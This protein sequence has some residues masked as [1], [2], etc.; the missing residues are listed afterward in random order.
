MKLFRNFFYLL[1]QG[2]IGIFRNSIM[3]TASIL[4]LIC[5]MLIVG[6]FGL[7]VKAV[8]DNLERTNDLNVIVA[9]ISPSATDEDI[10][11]TKAE[12]EAYHTGITVTYI[13]KETGLSRL[14]EEM[15]SAI[16]LSEY[17]NGERPN[18]LPDAFEITFENAEGAEALNNFINNLEN[19]TDTRHRIGLVD[20]VDDASKGLMAIA[21]VLMGMLFIVALFVIM[22]TIKLGVFARRDEIAVMRYV[23]ATN[24]FIVT[25]Y[26]IE[27][28]II[29]IFS[30]A[31]AFGIQYYLYT[32][33][34]ADIVVSS[35]IGTVAPFGEIAV[36]VAAG[37]LGLGLFAGTVG[38][39]VSI[40]KYLGQ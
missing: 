40:K 8:D 12:I 27:G 30:A 2:I 37:F 21:V 33:V 15:G 14:E 3:S 38:S 23:G 24:A 5:C 35:G 36:M 1:G 31:V 28:V 29:G 16:D 22:N 6:T 17:A 7:I 11:K 26:I 39:A 32:K 10:S 9:F 20:R 34:I 13:D 19:I 18:P 4:V 25:P